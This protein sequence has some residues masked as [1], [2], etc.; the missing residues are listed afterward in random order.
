[1]SDFIPITVSYTQPTKCAKCATMTTQGI[2]EYSE[3]GTPLIEQPLCPSCIQVLLQQYKLHFAQ[4]YAR[5]RSAS[6]QD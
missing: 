1:M 3:W 5:R 6:K 4:H 2:I